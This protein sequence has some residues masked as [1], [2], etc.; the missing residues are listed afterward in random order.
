MSQSKE[1][2]EAQAEALEKF[3]S[4]WHDMRNTTI[5]QKGVME[6]ALD[7]A[8]TLRA[9]AAL[10]RAQ[11]AAQGED[12]WKLTMHFATEAEADKVA[13]FAMEATNECAIIQ[14]APQSAVAQENGI[15]AEVLMAL[16]EARWSV[17]AERDMHT[18]AKHAELL[19]RID[20]LLTKYSGA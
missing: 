11:V 6:S 13:D 3:A 20:T 9:Q 19:C 5:R 4:D 14:A 17:K 8:A 18:S 10:P 12:G 16:R 7:R 1:V 2:L 15:P